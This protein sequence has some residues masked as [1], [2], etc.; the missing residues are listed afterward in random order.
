VESILIPRRARR[1]TRCS[2]VGTIS[3]PSVWRCPV[4]TVLVVTENAALRDVYREIL[5][6]GGHSLHVAETVPEALV[7]LAA[8]APV[9]LVALKVSGDL[10]ALRTA[11]AVD[12]A[13]GR[14]DIRLIMASGA[15]REPRRAALLGTAAYVGKPFTPEQIL[16]AIDAAVAR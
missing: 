15:L 7:A 13:A 2:P 16:A 9:V 12:R 4:A 5:T 8:R 11:L 14:P 1:I 10:A 6:I 3:L